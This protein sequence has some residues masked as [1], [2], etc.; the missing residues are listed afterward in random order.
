MS[1]EAIVAGLG[2]LFGGGTIAAIVQAVVS[3][4]KGIRDADVASDQIA[5]AGFKDLA[6]E[7][8]KEVDRLKQARE[9]GRARLDR[10][11]EQIKTERNTKWAAIQHIRNL[12]AWITQ[13]IRDVD[14]PPVPQDLAAHVIIPSRKDHDS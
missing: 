7:L 5:I 2:V 8:R 12:Y 14:P 13:H 4:K 3:H 10:I 6:E 9:E 11:E 1:P